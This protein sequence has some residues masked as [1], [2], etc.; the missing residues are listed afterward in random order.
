MI[1]QI[2][3]SQKVV[4]GFQAVLQTQAFIATEAAFTILCIKASPDNM[5]FG[6]NEYDASARGVTYRQ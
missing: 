1:M 3:S 6:T 2:T 4:P 5:F